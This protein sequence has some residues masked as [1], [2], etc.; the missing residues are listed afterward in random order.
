MEWDLFVGRFHSLLVH[1]PIGI[2]ILAYLF[3]VLL[4]LGFRSL[5][6]SRKIIIVTYIVGLLAGI[7]AAVTGWLLSFSDDYSLEALNDHK[8]LGITT[9]VV[10]ALVIIYQAKAPAHRNKLKLLAST[11]AIIFTGLT[12]HFGGN[13]THGP[14][15]LVEYGPN[16]FK[17]DTGEALQTLREIHPDSLNIYT[18]IVNPLIQN[19]CIACHN[20]EENKG[21][22]ILED[23]NDLFE[24]A[25]HGKPVLAGNPDMSE[26]FIRASLPK[27]HEKV[28]PPR[29]AGFGY[30][31]LQ[32]L[33]YW[34]NSGADSLASFNSNDMTEELIRLVHRDYGLDYSPKP[35]YEKVEVDSL[36]EGLLAQLRSA[37]FRVNY[38]GETNLLL[39][40]EYRGDSIGKDEIHMLNEVSNH[41]TF[42]KLS[43]CNL[44]DDLLGEI[45]D[46]QHL[47]KIDVSKNNLT[48]EMTPFLT[49]HR[50]LESANLN[51]TEIDIESLR[52]LLTQSG[53]LRVYVR[54]TKVAAEELP[55]LAQTYTEKEIIADFKFDKVEEAKSVFAQKELE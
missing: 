43:D 12:G 25:D 6:P 30:T 21:G 40:V 54:N 44:S 34:I 51:D 49:K 48:G 2:F 18:D 35:Y 38:L 3:E 53:L 11:I 4:Q 24:E 23:Y 41:I 10:M 37:N 19:K 17:S 42:L 7:V 13:L 39:D 47:T 27:E 36:D 28:M 46:I 1:L 29:E 14:T 8:L 16:I 45:A 26:L 32:I 22:L 55:S 5:I 20:R 52:N 9:L 15:Y 33:R 31:D 50:H